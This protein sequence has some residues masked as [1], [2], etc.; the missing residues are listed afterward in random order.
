MEKQYA[1]LQDGIAVEYPLTEQ[2]IRAR[3][4]LVSFPTAFRAPEGYVEVKLTDKPEHDEVLKVAVQTAPLE[5]DGQWTAVWQVVDRFRDIQRTADGRPAR[6]GRARPDEELITITK[7]EQEA[8]ALQKHTDKKAVEVRAHRNELLAGSDW[9]QMGDAP[10]DELKK[11]A[12]VEYRQ[13]LR[14]ITEQ[15]GF[16]LEVTLPV[17][18]Q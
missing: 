1:R 4:P 12:W 13:A 3:Y 9:T 11:Q 14:D 17:Q 18:P 5:I 15:D 2:T 8:E 7:A 10:L 6:G 16:P